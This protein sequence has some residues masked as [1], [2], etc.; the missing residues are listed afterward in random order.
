[1]AGR[2]RRLHLSLCILGCAIGKHGDD[3]EWIEMSERF[4]IDGY[5]RIQSGTK[6]VNRT[7]DLD[8]II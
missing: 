1:V 2:G 8:L 6:C 3:A 7:V 4:S 5:V